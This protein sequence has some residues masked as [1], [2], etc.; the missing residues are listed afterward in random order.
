MSRRNGVTLLVTGTVAV[1]KI[2]PLMLVRI[3][4]LH[5]RCPGTKL[6]DLSTKLLARQRA[7][8]P[9][10]L[11]SSQAAAAPQADLIRPDVLSSKPTQ[12][13]LP[14][15]S[16]T[17]PP[18]TY[19]PDHVTEYKPVP[20][21]TPA[22]LLN[23]YFQLSKARL[24]TLMVLTAM[25]G[26]AI[27]P[28][29]ATLSVL[30][31]TAA[32]T[33]LC[34]ASANTI[35]QIIEQPLDAQMPR[36][37]NRPLVRRAISPLHAATF[38]AVTGIAGP[39]MLF[40]L[41]NPVTAALGFANI[42]LYAG[43]YTPM[44]RTSIANTWV[45]A[46][47]GGIPPLMGWTA[48]GGHFLPTA[49]HPIQLVA[50]PAPLDAL[51]SPSTLDI[52]STLVT[53]V[54]HASDNPLSGV[55]LFLLLF[56]W[57]FPHFNPLARMVRTAYAQGAYKMLAVTSPHKNTVVSLRHALLLIPI[58]SVLTPISGLTTWMFAA[59][60][61]VP[62]AIFVRSAWKF[63]KTG[64][65]KEARNLFHTSLVYLPLIMGLMMVHKEG[66]DWLESI[67]IR[68]SSVKQE[69]ASPIVES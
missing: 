1:P 24:T 49:A 29:P 37:R 40:T 51:I 44:K 36:T 26:V 58:C 53:W 30:L 69:D 9:R 57:Q 14:P 19:P 8:R 59:T 6:D 10:R 18:T 54:G 67:G 22:R 34:S 38:A 60:S 42:I 43:V 62:N 68:P 65:E 15:V 61:L 64:R 21:L 39:A 17:S 12:T 7:V 13:G 16:I 46:V 35:N 27:S 11:V 4:T 2:P 52:T 63:Y 50:P 32:G 23:V 47:V 48:C 45:G 33:A 5:C 20:S 66:T 3:R 31:G 41:V 56:S 28:L 25:S 55:T